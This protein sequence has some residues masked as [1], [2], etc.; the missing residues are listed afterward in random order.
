MFEAVFTNFF[1]GTERNQLLNVGKP[2]TC[3]YV[4]LYDTESG[5]TLLYGSNNINTIIKLKT[6]SP[7]TVLTQWQT[8]I[9][10]EVIVFIVGCG[11]DE[12]KL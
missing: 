5:L 8:G 1:F 10:W 9:K 6:A 2:L 4:S 11:C 12:E 7:I 3:M